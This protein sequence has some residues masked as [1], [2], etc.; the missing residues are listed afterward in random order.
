M[1]VPC[2]MPRRRRL[3]FGRRMSGR[4]AVGLAHVLATLPPRRIR[5]VLR[6]L[7]RGARPATAVQARR[8]R[9]TVVAVS[10]FCAGE[11]CVQRSLATVLLCRMRGVWPTWCLGVRTEPFRA[12]AWVEVDGEPIGEQQRAGYYRPLIMVPEP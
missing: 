9:E 11:G 7:R 3:P 12:H 2:A 8:A 4:V 10:L 5:S 6:L 1:S